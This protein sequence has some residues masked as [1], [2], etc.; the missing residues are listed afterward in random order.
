MASCLFDPCGCHRGLVNLSSG[1][2]PCRLEKAAL[3]FMDFGLWIHNHKAISARYSSWW[4]YGQ[5]CL[6]QLL[7]VSGK[8]HGDAFWHCNHAPH[9]TNQYCKRPEMTLLALAVMLK[10]RSFD[11]LHRDMA[12]LSSLYLKLVAILIF[13]YLKLNHMAIGSHKQKPFSNK[14]KWCP[15]NCY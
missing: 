3:K 12:T 11:I 14:N 13:P 9:G 10:L 15:C 2:H 5:K 8:V 7:T 4:F 6:V 1:F